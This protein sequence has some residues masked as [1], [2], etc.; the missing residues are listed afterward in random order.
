MPCPLR[1]KLIL[2]AL[3]NVKPRYIT[4]A[5]DAIKEKYGSVTEYC[6]QVIKITDEEISELRNKYLE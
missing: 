1:I 2:N 3:I 6:K 5:I 4:G